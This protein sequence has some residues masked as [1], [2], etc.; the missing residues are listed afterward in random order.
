MDRF[1]R[2]LLVANLVVML[3]VLGSFVSAHGGDTSRIHA[4]VDSKGLIRIIGANGT[5]TA[6]KET[7]LDWNIQGPQGPQGPAGASGTSYFICPN[8]DI[9]SIL[10]RLNR[11]DLT[12]ANLDY[13]NLSGSFLLDADLTGATLVNAV[14]TKMD[15]RG[16]NLTDANLTNA[17]LRDTQLWGDNLTRANLTGADLTRMNFGGGTKLTNA[18]LTNASLEGSYVDT[19]TVDLTGVIWSNTTC[20]D[21]TNSDNNGG[22]CEGHF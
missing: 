16:I 5:C 18:N 11:Q 9:R 7:P 15:T 12:N 6:G 20:R 8:C 1:K 13:A 22:T 19:S 14:L 4:C 17:T 2:T 21:G 10:I 3:L